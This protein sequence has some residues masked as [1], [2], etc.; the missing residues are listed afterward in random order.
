M[1]EGN[2]CMS[3]YA[4]AHCRLSNPPPS[5]PLPLLVGKTG[6][7]P[8]F[9]PGFFFRRGIGLGVSSPPEADAPDGVG[10]STGNTGGDGGVRLC[11]DSWPEVL[12]GRCVRSEWLWDFL[13][14][15]SLRFLGTSGAIET[16]GAMPLRSLLFEAGAM[17]WG[18]RGEKKVLL[19]QERGGLD[20]SER[21][22]VDEDT[23]GGSN[24]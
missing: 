2:L 7:F 5:L 10:L 3:T 19:G 4:P 16:E 12:G 24:S 13:I 23:L 22:G 20:Q 21:L 17:S 15:S 6:D 1:L 9:F 14:P 11:W 18:E 8:P